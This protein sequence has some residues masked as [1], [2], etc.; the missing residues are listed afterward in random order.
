MSAM[1]LGCKFPSPAW[2]KTTKSISYFA[3]ISFN[4]LN[5]SGI[6]LRGTVASSEIFVGFFL[7]IAGDTN[8]L[9]FHNSIA[10]SSFSAMIKFFAPISKQI[11]FIF[12]ISASIAYGCPS[13]SI[14]I[15][16]S[17]SVGSP[18]GSYSSTAM[19]D[20]WSI[21]SIFAGKIPELKMFEM[22]RPE[23]TKSSN[24]TIIVCDATGLGMRR[25]VASVIIPNV[26]SE[27]TISFVKS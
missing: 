26:P 16:A 5:I 10:C 20:D 27:P 11:F 19:I 15:I 1:M 21:I 8:F 9:A 14:K 13:S 24:N 6:L 2:P 4:F 18:S 7:T 23:T 25:S 3:F 17:I 22:S 12:F